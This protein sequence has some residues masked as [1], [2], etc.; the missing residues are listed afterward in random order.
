VTDHP[1]ASAPARLERRNPPVSLQRIWAMSLR[2]LYLLRGS[3]PRVL[4]MAYWPTVQ[5]IMWGFIT[6]FLAQ[7]SSYIAQGFGVLLSGVLLW[8]VLFRSQL[9]VSISFLEEMWSRNLAHVFASPLRPGEFITAITF[10]SLVRTLLGI[11]P[12]T[13]MAIAFFGFS[14]YSLGLS[15]AVF[16]LI[17]SLLGWSIGLATSG[18]ILR[19]GLGAESLAWVSIFALAPISGIYYPIAVLPDWLQVVAWCLPSAYVFEGMRAIV[20]DG[21]VRIDLMLWGLGLN[22]VYFALGVTAFMLALRS[23]RQ[24]AKL[25][26][27]GE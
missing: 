6:Q 23:A 26:Q 13:L 8:D 10:M 2:Y 9:G 14:V 5:M 17:L 27:V 16:F 18:L 22:V 4:E 3:W 1:V 24:R 25:M 15:L 12:A 19:F 7:N 20:L 21:V 11:I